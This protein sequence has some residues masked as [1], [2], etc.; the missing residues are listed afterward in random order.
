MSLEV[1]LV[2]IVACVTS[3]ATVCVFLRSYSRFYILR[4][5]SVDDYLILVSL[6]QAWI[7][8]GL[9]ISCMS[10][11]LLENILLS[12][13]I[14]RRVGLGRHDYEV[15]VQNIETLLKVSIMYL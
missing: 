12:N 5:A 2:A 11:A 4:K 14:V 8:A 6:L 1:A 9:L 7:L 10:L 15:P 3:L 13:I